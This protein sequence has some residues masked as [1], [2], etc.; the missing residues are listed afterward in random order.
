MRSLLCCTIVAATLAA[1][2]PTLAAPPVVLTKDGKLVQ[3]LVVRDVQGGFAGFTGTEWSV[4]PSGDYVVSSVRRG[5]AEAQKKGRLRPQQLAA[6]VKALARCDAAKELTP[7]KA[8]DGA[9]PHV[10]S[11][12]V[13]ERQFSLRLPP[14][15]KPPKADP[16]KPP[17]SETEWFA[18]VLQTVEQAAGRKP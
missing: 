12:K 6:L 9:N 18:A 11:V 16:D 3:P 4:N 5:K 8:F 1:T 10:I 7:A 2:S 17:T 15:A 14:G 13:G